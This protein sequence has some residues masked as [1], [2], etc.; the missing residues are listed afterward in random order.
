MLHETVFFAAV[1]KKKSLILT[2]GKSWLRLYKNYVYI[3]IFN[4]K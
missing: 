4:V 1:K 3:C 2:K